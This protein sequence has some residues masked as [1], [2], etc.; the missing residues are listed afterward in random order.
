MLT[1][2]NYDRLVRH[3]L[4]GDQ[5]VTV[6]D[7]PRAVDLAFSPA[8]NLLALT[9]ARED[10]MGALYVAPVANPTE[11]SDPRKLVAEDRNFIAAPE[12]SPD[13]KVLYYLSQRDG[14]KCVWAQPIAP[15]GTPAG[16]P[17]AA[18]HLHPGG[19]RMGGPL[20]VAVA[21]GQLFVLKTQLRGDVWSVQLDR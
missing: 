6:A 13:G 8:G 7:L 17:V 3:R 9:E 4:G 2:A 10:G 11:K 21:K 15:H 1:G 14:F 16:A 12:W 18:L 20:N 19:G 5:Q